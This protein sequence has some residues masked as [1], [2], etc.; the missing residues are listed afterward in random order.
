MAIL[1]IVRVNGT[2]PST[3]KKFRDGN[4]PTR[5]QFTQNVWNIRWESRI[6]LSQY[7]P[8]L[9]RVGI[10]R[11]RLCKPRRVEG[12]EHQG[13]ILKGDR[14]INH[15]AIKTITADEAYVSDRSKSKGCACVDSVGPR[16]GHIHLG[17]L[18]G[19]CVRITF[20]R[21]DFKL[22]LAGRHTA[23]RKSI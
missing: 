1:L 23:C 12:C 4:L 7:S 6:D 3:G 18:K 5:N 21:S 22:E 11:C 14:G 9:L 8:R 13:Y 19:Q 15:L 17:S 16:G 2:S 20:V 10:I